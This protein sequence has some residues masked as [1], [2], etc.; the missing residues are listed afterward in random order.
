MYAKGGTTAAS[1]RQHNQND[2]LPVII[3]DMESDNPKNYDINQG[4]INLMRQSSSS[5]EAKLYKGTSDHEGAEFTTNSSFCCNSI[6]VP[7]LEAADASRITVIEKLQSTE[8]EFE[9]IKRLAEETVLD[10]LY[11]A[12]LRAR[13]RANAPNIMANVKTFSKALARKLGAARSGDQLGTLVASAYGLTST[14]IISQEDADRWVSEQD[15]SVA[16][17]SKADPDHETCLRHLLDSTLPYPSTPV[18]YYSVAELVARLKGLLKSSADFDL[19]NGILHRSGMYWKQ[20]VLTVAAVHPGL[21]KIFKN[22][23]WADGSWAQ[24]LARCQGPES[25]MDSSKGG[26]RLNT[27]YLGCGDARRAVRV[28]YDPPKELQPQDDSDSD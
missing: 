8:E 10:P 11:C 17:A 13:A 20:G 12:Q 19:I 28:L 21:K 24:C 5:D 6:S 25:D 1:I 18:V 14:G 4:V 22:T 23:R 7:A 9:A 26:R 2:A 27:F 15:W 3:D 16:N